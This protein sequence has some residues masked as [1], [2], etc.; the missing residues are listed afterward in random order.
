MKKKK[1]KNIDRIFSYGK[2][3]RPIS[4]KRTRS[5]FCSTHLEDGGHLLLLA[6]RAVVLDRQDDG[7]GRGDEGRLGDGLDDL[8]EGDLGGER[9]AVVDDGLAVVPV[10]AVELDAPAPSQ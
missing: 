2:K 7:E 10:P 4:R 1:K 8:P 5:K 3:Y 9:V 6:D